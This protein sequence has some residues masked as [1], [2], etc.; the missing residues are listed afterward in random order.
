[1]KNS[2]IALNIALTIAVAV[3][4]Y[5]HFSEGT[6]QPKESKVTE[7]N[8]VETPA[9]KETPAPEDTVS[10]GTIDIQL[11][12]KLKN[13]PILYVNVDYL[14]KNCKYMTT[15]AADMQTTLGKWANDLD[16]KEQQMAN[17]YKDY[18]EA[19]AAGLRSRQDL[20]AM[21]KELQSM[22]AEFDRSEMKAQEAKEEF[23][24]KNEK[25]QKKIFSVIRKYAVENKLSF[26]FGYTEMG[27]NVLYANESLDISK[28]VV[29]ALNDQ[30][31]TGKK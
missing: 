11:S 16:T 9:A 14:S 25:I 28:E 26:I 5:W 8:A 29:K 22:K 30:Y 6:T 4:F 10:I 19:A 12:E 13:Q 20:E 2:L 1:M 31:G 27:S 17:K 23:G 15:L 21:E 24:K 18:Q 7:T 3:L